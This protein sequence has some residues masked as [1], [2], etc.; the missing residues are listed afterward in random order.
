MI[1]EVLDEPELEFAGGVGHID[2]RFGLMHAGPIDVLDVK[3]RSISVALVGTNETV[4]SLARWLER[5]R[6]EIPGKTSPYP[7]LFPRFPGFNPQIAFRST[8]LLGSRTQR[9]IAQRSIANAIKSPRSN[10]AVEASVEIFL[11]EMR[12]IA[13]KARPDVLIC[14]PP[15]DLWDAVQ[16]DRHNQPDSEDGVG[17][18]VVQFDFHDMLKARA[19]AL[20]VPVQLVWP[21]TYDAGRRRQQKRRPER[22]RNPQDEATRAWNLHTALYYKAGGL[23]WRIVRDPSQLSTC[24]VGVSFY[25]SLE[26]VRLQ[27]STAQVFNE[28]GDGVVVRGGQAAI[29][30]EDRQPHLDEGAAEDLLV[31][32]LATYRR[33][34]K[35]PPARIVMHK[36]SRYNAAELAGF[37]SAADRAGIEE[38]DF[39]TVDESFIRLFR[40]E[41]HPPLRGTLLSLDAHSHVLYTKG[42]VD[43]F[44]MYPGSYVPLPLL[45]RLESTEQTPH[46]LGSELL[47]LTKM[48]WNSAQFDGHDPISV[49]AARQVGSILRYVGPNDPVEPAYGHY[50]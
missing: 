16:H 25:E 1:A 17:T 42:S 7:N 15:S 13:E 22:T 36:T 2:I 49:R 37:R 19:M 35:A 14:A 20:R 34:H 8:L 23:P 5:C 48:N 12:Y 21:H 32:A 31:G 40:H 44:Q 9:T 30:K 43:F 24:C 39:L 29:S 4:E 41:G 45:F 26:G 6:G 18:D 50:M 10:Q 47:A 33:E 11:D 3:P 27:T 38:V 28:R 46:F